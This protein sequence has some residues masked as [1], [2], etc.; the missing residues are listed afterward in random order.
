MGLTK[1]AKYN[2]WHE[3]I[4]ISKEYQNE[5]PELKIGL[6]I[7]HQRKWHNL[8][9][10]MINIKT[11]KNYLAAY[12]LKYLGRISKDVSKK[13]LMDQLDNLL[14]NQHKR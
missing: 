14:V 10:D 1:M 11:G 9:V 2:Y 3:I 6:C 13:D 8:S 4:D 12:T 7:T 5:H